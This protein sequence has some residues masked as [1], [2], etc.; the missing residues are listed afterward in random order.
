[1][2]EY[3]LH[4]YIYIYIYMHILH[5]FVVYTII[6]ACLYAICIYIRTYHHLISSMYIFDIMITMCIFRLL[7][8]CCS[9]SFLDASHPRLF[10]HGGTL[11]PCPVARCRSGHR[12]GSP[13][14]RS[15]SYAGMAWSVDMD[16]EKGAW[17]CCAFECIEKMK[18]DRTW[19]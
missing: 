4:V 15:P 9:G 7:L 3:I 11:L 5:V 13:G 17:K 12:R 6:Y 1:M 10:N 18:H 8:K 2:F 14:L 19:I 16:T